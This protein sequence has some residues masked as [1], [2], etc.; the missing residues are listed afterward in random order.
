MVY[1]YNTKLEFMTEAIES[2]ST[3][4]SESLEKFIETKVRGKKSNGRRKKNLFFLESFL[5]E[6]RKQ[7]SK[8]QI[9]C[10]KH[11]K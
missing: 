3:R 7:H 11:S 5:S 8:K 6:I 4:N 10:E 2:T 1:T 9:Y